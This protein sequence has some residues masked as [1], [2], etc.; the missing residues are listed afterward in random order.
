MVGYSVLMA[1]LVVPTKD[2]GKQAKWLQWTSYMKYIFQALNINALKG[3]SAEFLLTYLEC[4][5]MTIWGNVL[6]LMAF[7]IP[8][9]IGCYI[10][11][12]HCNKELR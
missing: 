6:V 3:T 2:F 8:T 9:L 7:Y 4:K 10:C 5:P 1:G 12:R 11:L